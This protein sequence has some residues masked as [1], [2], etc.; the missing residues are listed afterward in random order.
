MP[1]TIDEVSPLSVPQACPVT[2]GELL[3]ESDG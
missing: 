2:V 3:A 1:E